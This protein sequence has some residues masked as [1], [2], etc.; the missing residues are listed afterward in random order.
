MIM[1]GPA[2]AVDI[3]STISRTSGPA[4]SWKA[5]LVVDLLA[6]AVPLALVIEPLAQ[7]ATLQHSGA[8]L[9]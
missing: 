8:A 7:P 5:R 9:R 6:A 4:P 3:S 2:A 1:V